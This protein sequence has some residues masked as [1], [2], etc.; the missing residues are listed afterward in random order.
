MQDVK[1]RQS[2]ASP[3]AVKISPP[4]MSWLCRM[5]C[6]HPV[7]QQ[8]VAERVAVSGCGQPKPQRVK[9]ERL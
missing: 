8:A 4:W 5:L 1:T 7:P 3:R 9:L 6:L 2:W